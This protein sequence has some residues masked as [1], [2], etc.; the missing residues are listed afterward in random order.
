MLRLACDTAAVNELQE[1]LR[2]A[3]ESM[4]RLRDAVEA[5]EPW[6][7]SASYGVEPESSWGPREVLAHVAEMIPFWLGEIDRIV[8]ADAGAPVPFGRVAT[9]PARIE[10]IGKDRMLPIGELFERIGLA[11]YGAMRVMGGLSEPDRA[12][13]GMHPRRGEMS[14]NDSFDQFIV[15]HL[16]EHVDQLRE[17]LSTHEEDR[18]TDRGAD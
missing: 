16:E 4:L 10:R 15:H 9:D 18:T 6:P 1:R 3:T 2:S 8:S 11:S 14:V 13:L 17:A 7:L 5:G 12:R